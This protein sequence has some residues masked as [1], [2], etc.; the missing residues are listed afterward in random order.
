[1]EVPAAVTLNEVFAAA[2]TVL[3]T[4]WVLMTVVGLTVSIAGFEFTVSGAQ[5]PVTTHR[6]WY[7]VIPAVAPVIFK[8]AVVAPLYTPPFE[9]LFHGPPAPAVLNCH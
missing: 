1:M 5:F 8:V 7:V 4:G 9:I 6:Y 2:Q 3:L